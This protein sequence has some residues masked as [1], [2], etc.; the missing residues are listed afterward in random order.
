MLSN[1][2]DIVITPTLTQFILEWIGYACW[3]TVLL[4]MRTVLSNFKAIGKTILVAISMGTVYLA[5]IKFARDFDPI[6]S[7]LFVTLPYYG[8]C[9]S[10]LILCIL[11]VANR[12]R[13]NP[14][15][16]L[17]RKFAIIAIV[18]NCF[19][20][21]AGILISFI[22]F[23]FIPGFYKFSG[24]LGFIGTVPTFFLLLYFL[25]IKKIQSN[26]LLQTTEETSAWPTVNDQ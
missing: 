3:F 1:A 8:M 6:I 14:L 10:Y 25:Q 15:I 24:I 7:I 21:I 5:F 20:F 9:I 17:L 13:Q 2:N 12:D 4:I 26:G 16:K 11:I 22:S 18:I 19:N 23:F